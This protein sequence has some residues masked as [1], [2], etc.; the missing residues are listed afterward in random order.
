[1]KKET[2]NGSNG[3]I[4]PYLSKV[5]GNEKTVVIFSHG[6]GSS[7]ESPAAHAVASVLPK[8]GI[9]TYIF[10]FPAHGNSPVDG[11]RFRISNCLDDLAA[12]E[13][14]IHE[15]MPKAEI[16]YFSSSFGAYI[17]LIYLATR[18]H[19]GNKSFLRCAAVSMPELFKNNATPEQY[20]LIDR[21]GYIIMDYGFIRPLK[22]TRE[23]Y[24]DLQTHDLFKL[25]RPDMAEL[26]MIHGDA[27]EI[28]PITE[29]RRFAKQFGVKLTEV[30]GADHRFTIPGGMEQ[31]I[32]A[33]VEFFTAN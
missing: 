16:A 32:T 5:N 25:C 24:N 26:A 8:Y 31:V 33:A 9:G 11:E 13:A 22:I 7:K 21:Q 28:A 12:I 1:M 29:V 10:D 17:N 27:D 3:Y 30:N 18:P 14:H 6:F 23:F 20:T 4:I 15:L 19:I 2:I